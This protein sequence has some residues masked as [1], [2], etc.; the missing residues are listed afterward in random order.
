MDPLLLTRKRVR[1]LGTIFNILFFAGMIWSIFVSIVAPYWYN[2]LITGLYFLVLIFTL[3]MTTI[4]QANIGYIRSAKTS[5]PIKNA[6]IYIYDISGK[7]VDSRM[8]DDQG[9]YQMLLPKGTYTLVAL[10]PGYLKHEETVIIPQGGKPLAKRLALQ[11]E[12]R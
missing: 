2:L 4:D 9:K 5:A 12:S 7:S 10:A 8:T 6:G 11:P 3:I 1:I